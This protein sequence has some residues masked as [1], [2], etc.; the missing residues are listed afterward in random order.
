M[1]Q[2]RAADGL[3]QQSD[4]VQPSIA[5]MDRSAWETRRRRW[6]TVFL[7]GGLFPLLNLTGYPAY[8]VRLG[9]GY[10]CTSAYWILHEVHAQG[11]PFTYRYT[12]RFL[13]NFDHPLRTARSTSFCP[14]ALGLNLLVV[15]AI[16]LAVSWLLAKRKGLPR[17]AMTLS[18]LLVIVTVVAIATAIYAHHQTRH[19]RERNRLEAV[20]NHSTYFQS[21]DVG[22]QRR[23]HPLIRR[24]P[25]LHWLKSMD[26]IGAIA[27]PGKAIQF[28]PDLED[29]RVVTVKWQ[30]TNQEL[31]TLSQLPKLEALNILHA[32]AGPKFEPAPTA[33]LI[34]PQLQAVRWL[35]I[36]GVPNRI[37]GYRNLPNL[38]SAWL[39]DAKVDES[40]VLDLAELNRLKRLQ[41]WH[42]QVSAEV[43]RLFRSLSSLETLA[44]Y[45]S[46]LDGDALNQL[47]EAKHLR[48]LWL[49]GCQLTDDCI[50]MLESMPHLKRLNVSGNAFSPGGIQRL[51]S[52]LPGCAIDFTS[53]KVTGLDV[54]TE[55]ISIP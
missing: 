13:L 42:C 45:G 34:L 41:L 3:R 50:P 49:L 28:L 10:H 6:Q 14:L 55:F 20:I 25:G 38:E 53:D 29:L 18:T 43:W 51:R 9:T 12:D 2:N 19:Q 48:G 44:V 32:F 21:H 30:V 54:V 22:W 15:V 47:A 1:S 7:F 27:L 24:M 46:E 37:S 39:A 33:E 40:T 26:R 8:D 4:D 36:A 35:A 52:A 11:W 31:T 5:G 23:G 17:Y 16:S